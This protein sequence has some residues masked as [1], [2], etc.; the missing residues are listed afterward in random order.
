M[1]VEKARRAQKA[2]AAGVII[3][4]NT[5]G[6]NSATSPLFSMSGDG[7]NDV[8]IPVVFLL[9]QEASKVLLAMSVDGATLFSLKELKSE[10]EL[11][12]PN[13]EESVFQKLKMSVQ[14]FLNKHTGIV[15]TQSVKHGDFK[16]DIGIDKIR[17][18]YEKA[19]KQ[20]QLPTEKTANQQW[21]Q[22]RRGLIRYLTNIKYYYN[23]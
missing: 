12:P 22:I 18:S 4:D 7:T 15:F 2:G 10:T 13:E 3:V 17:V 19:D 1:F 6:S 9:A 16:A 23:G 20:V 5:P 8:T 21:S 14:E 11:W